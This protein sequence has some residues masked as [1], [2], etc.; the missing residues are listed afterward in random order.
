MISTYREY[1]K[2]P[3]SLND[4]HINQVADKLEYR[5]KPRIWYTGQLYSIDGTPRS[6]PVQFYSTSGPLTDGAF[7]GGSAGQYQSNLAF[8]MLD[9]Y[10]KISTFGYNGHSWL[11][12]GGIVGN[13]LNGTWASVKA[14]GEFWAGAI[15]SSS[16]SYPF[17]G[18][19][20]LKVWG[21]NNHGQLGQ[22]DTSDRGS[23][24]QIPGLWR[25]FYPYNHVNDNDTPST[26]NIYG[27]CFG[28]TQ[29]GTL[30]SWGYNGNG[31]LGQSDT[32]PRS[33]PIQIP[34]NSSGTWRSFQRM[35]KFCFAIDNWGRLWS[36]GNNS[37]GQLGLND[38]VA[39]SSPNLVYGY[40]NGAGGQDRR[41]KYVV[42]SY[43][44]KTCYA[45]D[46]SG[47]LWAWGANGHGELGNGDTIPRS[48]PCQIPGSWTNVVAKDNTV[49][50]W[51]TNT[52]RLYS[53]G[54]NTSYQI[55]GY[56]DN[57]NRSR[58][59]QIPGKWNPRYGIYFNGSTCFAVKDSNVVGEVPGLYVWGRNEYGQAFR[60]SSSTQVGTPL[61]TSFFPESFRSVR[62]DSLPSGFNR[63]YCFWTMMGEYS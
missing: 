36:W 54:Q 11:G 19:G 57:G 22:G 31:E 33:S 43:N 55:L 2:G 17:T 12:Q 51:E 13:T 4:L 41:W 45:F 3:T 44:M 48:S 16:T 9:Q 37:Q 25:D 42:N 28:L 15:E 52:N 59:T 56:G 24:S 61:R 39:R 14:G 32:T 30:W 63:D 58:P 10:G 26:V 38:V 60:N 8:F 29:S 50:A 21:R 46:S 6:S 47:G 27:N 23:P 7:T 40:W 53:W 62:L 34:T 18:N 1:V 5:G 20:V 35:G 49:F